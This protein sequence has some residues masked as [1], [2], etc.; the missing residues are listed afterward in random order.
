MTETNVLLRQL[1]PGNA[2]G[3]GRLVLNPR[4][5][6][7]D[8]FQADGAIMD[9]SD[10]LTQELHDF[11]HTFEGNKDVGFKSYLS[12]I[13]SASRDKRTGSKISLSTAT[14]TTQYLQNSESY[15]DRLCD[16]ST[17]QFWL[18][19]AIRRSQNVYL[20]TGIKTIVEASLRDETT[21]GATIQASVEAPLTM[22]AAAAG[23]P[24]PIDGLLDQI[25]AVQYRK[26]CFGWFSRKKIDDARLEEG[27]KWRMYIGGRGEEEQAEQDVSVGLDDD[28][29]ELDH[30]TGNSGIGYICNEKYIY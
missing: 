14:C 16:L 5:P 7:Q 30:S 12:K 25:F 18:E 17:C 15:L 1:L 20:V 21:S 23:V 4:F 26:L 22:V 11:K 6:E 9:S 19:R 29:G 3:L 2:V 8:F 24:L 27:N 10:V 13:L 28:L